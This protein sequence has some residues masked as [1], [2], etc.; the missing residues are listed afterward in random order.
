MELQTPEAVLGLMVVHAALRSEAADI[1]AGATQGGDRVR[2]ARRSRLLGRVIHVHH[3]G[4]DDLLWPALRAIDPSFAPIG[5]GFV[6][7]HEMLDARIEDLVDRFRHAGRDDVVTTAAGT[8]DALEAHLVAEERD[9]IPRWLAS[10]GPDEHADFANRLQRATPLGDVAVMV[11]W[12]LDR[13]QGPAREMVWEQLPGALRALYRW[14][15]KANFER[16]YGIAR[17]EEAPSAL[18]PRLVRAEA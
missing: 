5:D 9:A 4:E 6:D 18:R 2:L 13:A 1:V 16:T 12:L 8:R 15:W 10:F 14:R 3:R 11:S 17:P 7:E